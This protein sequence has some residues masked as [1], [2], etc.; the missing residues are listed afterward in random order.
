MYKKQNDVFRHNSPNNSDAPPELSHACCSYTISTSSYQMHSRKGPRGFIVCNEK[1]ETREIS[2]HK[3][4][5]QNR[6]CRDSCTWLTASKTPVKWNPDIRQLRECREASRGRIHVGKLYVAC[7][8]LGGARP[9]CASRDA[10]ALIAHP[11]SRGGV[12]TRRV[13]P[14]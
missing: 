9:P 13:P 1:A 14:P 4:E 12:T 10:S 3:H 2:K 5:N 6:A 8:R 7:A 11:S